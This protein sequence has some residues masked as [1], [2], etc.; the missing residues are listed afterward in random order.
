MSDRY[1]NLIKIVITLIIFILVPACSVSPQVMAQQRLFLDLSLD[2]LGDYELSSQEWENTRVGGLSGLTYDRSTG[3]LL[4]IS[5]DRSYFAPA[6]F[7]TLN[8]SINETPTLEAVTIEGVT[9]LRN[10]QGETYATG[11]IDSEGIA[12]SPRETVYISSEGIPSS[13]IA[14]FVQEYDLATGTLQSSLTIPDRYQKSL[15]PPTG[16]GEN[17]GFESLTLG[18]NSL[19]P[20]DPFRVFTATESSLVQDTSDPPQES[21]PIRLMHYVVNSVGDPILVAEHF[22]FLE[23]APYADTLSNGLTELI[24]LNQEGYFLTLERTFSLSGFGA[25]IFQVVIA[26]AT[27]TSGV[28]SL[29]GDLTGVQPVQKQLLLDLEDLDLEL[30]NYEGMTLGPLL[31]DGTQSLILV[32]DDNFKEE[33]VTQFLLFR[34]RQ[35]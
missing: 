20:G 16:V 27:D 18:P 4:A 2:Y 24:A 1:P 30:D 21:A 12:L 9:F 29:S 17:L 22:Y 33:Q 28:V 19:A 25:K 23:P 32:S 14:P 7:Y 15:D 26:N 11:T 31:P 3:K 13:D 5:D 10:Q 34:L 8:L 6:R 35:N